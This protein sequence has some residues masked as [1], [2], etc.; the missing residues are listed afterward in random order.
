MKYWYVVFLLCLVACTGSSEQKE[1]SIRLWYDTPA[2]N[3]NEALPIGNGR[4]GAMVFGGTD[5]EQLQLN[6]NTLYSGE[7]TQRKHA[8]QRRTFRDVQRHKG[9]S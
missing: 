1:A 3:W 6:E 9:H 7:A 2:Q 8:L 4:L 5:K